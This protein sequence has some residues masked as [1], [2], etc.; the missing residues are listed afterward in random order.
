MKIEG[1][2]DDG[3]VKDKHGVRVPLHLM[4]S[5]QHAIGGQPRLHR[6]GQAQISPADA[7]VRAATYDKRDAWLA[8][9]WKGVDP[10]PEVTLDDEP[11]ITTPL[12]LGSDRAAVVGDEPAW[13]Q[14]YNTRIENAWKGAQS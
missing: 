3:I 5:V 7:E 9:A 12:L 11:V 10:E 1:E 14:N 6:P 13:V 8:D 4:D 2:D